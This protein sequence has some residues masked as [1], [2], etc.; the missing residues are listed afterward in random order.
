MRLFDIA[1][2]KLRAPKVTGS[3][4]GRRWWHWAGE[5]HTASGTDWAGLTYTLLLCIILGVLGGSIP[6]LWAGKEDR[7]VIYGCDRLE[8]Y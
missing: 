8:L 4:T 1:A 2:I 6:T 3:G 7:A 5:D